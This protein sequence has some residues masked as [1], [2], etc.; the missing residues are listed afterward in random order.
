M[1]SSL[2]ADSTNPEG[3]AE[4]GALHFKDTRAEE[5]LGFFREMKAD[6]L[7]LKERTRSIMTPFGPPMVQ[8]TPCTRSASSLSELARA[9]VDVCMASS[10]GV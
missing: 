2:K 3:A 7:A 4:C 10:V 9:D 6:F 5:G 8:C 1:L